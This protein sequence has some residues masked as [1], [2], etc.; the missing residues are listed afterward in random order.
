MPT[1]MPAP[2]APE[3]SGDARSGTERPGDGRPRQLLAV[4]IAVLL[5]VGVWLILRPITPDPSESAIDGG[6]SAGAPV[7][8]APAPGV[9]PV[10]PVPPSGESGFAAKLGQ[11]ADAIAP[12]TVGLARQV[13]TALQ[14]GSTQGAAEQAVIQTG[15][16]DQRSAAAF[17]AAAIENFCPEV[18]PAAVRTIKDGTW[19]AGADVEPGRYSTTAGADCSWQRSTS[20]DLGLAGLIDSGAGAGRQTVTLAAG[21]YLVTTRCGQ[22][23]KAR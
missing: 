9:P 8:Q 2:E 17:V 5:G 15:K 3:R 19:R 13:C 1:S 10:I 23:A 20:P 14:G 21:E 4:S 22:W 16:F 11:P 12:E 6:V 18:G 7:Q